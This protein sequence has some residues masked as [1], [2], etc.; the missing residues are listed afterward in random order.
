MFFFSFFLFPQ[1]RVTTPHIPLWPLPHSDWADW[2][3]NAAIEW[4]DS[5]NLVPGLGEF[6][7]SLG[8]V[9][10][11]STRNEILIGTRHGRR[12][13]GWGT[14][15]GNQRSIPNCTG[16]PGTRRDAMRRFFFIFFFDRFFIYLLF[17]GRIYVLHVRHAASPWT[18]VYR[19]LNVTVISF[20]LSKL[21]FFLFKDWENCRDFQK[22][23]RWKIISA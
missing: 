11:C 1:S 10:R 13:H 21:L 8:S 5:E 4:G 22:F 6:R 15:S 9:R 16:V 18:I 7:S 19:L 3:G 17:H 2:A 12:R 23:W 20:H 14:H